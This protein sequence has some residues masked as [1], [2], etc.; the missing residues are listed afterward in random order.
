VP[1]PVRRALPE[2]PVPRVDGE[3][4][5]AASVRFGRALHA[6]GLATDLTGARDFARALTMVE[7][8]DRELVRAAGAAIFVRHADEIAPYRRIFDRFWRVVGGTLE[9]P[10]PARRRQP[11]ASG[12][13]ADADADADAELVHGLSLRRVGYSAAERLRHRDFATLTPEELRDAERM[14][15]EL[16]PRLA[17]RRARRMEHASHARL[18]AP[19]A[20]LRANLANGA[21][22]IEWIWRRNRR[23]PRRLVVLVDI[24]GSM[25][26][27]ARLLL[28]F[29]HALSRTDAHVEAFV[30]GTQ[31]TRISHQLRERNPDRA[32]ALVAERARFGSGGTRIGEAFRAFNRDWARRVLPTSGVVIVLS[33]GWDHGKPALIAE[34]T[35]RLARGCHRLIWLNPLAGSADYRPLAA[36]MAAALPWVDHLLPAASVA[37]LAGL[38]RLLGSLGRGA[39]AA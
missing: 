37:D 2:L 28:R 21:E 29:T 18:L 1:D 32:L 10:A 19:R 7:I 5:L 38:G 6:E 14:I 39:V 35:Q 22:P 30:F 23:H 3:A 25:D 12:P 9:G 36:G 27:H 24:S 4:L 33:D 17:T 16:G 8:G 26:R 13:P 20:M 15:D 11:G 34:E 31:L